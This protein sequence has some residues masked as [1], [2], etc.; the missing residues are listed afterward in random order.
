MNDK[1]IESIARLSQSLVSELEIVVRET[2]LIEEKN[3]QIDQKLNRLH[4]VEDRVNRAII[5]SKAQNGALGV[6]RKE[7]EELHKS[8]SNKQTLVEKQTVVH[9]NKAKEMDQRESILIEREKVLSERDTTITER[10]SKLNNLKSILEKEQEGVR[11]FKAKLE[12]QE[13]QLKKKSDRIM[14]IIK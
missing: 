4:L 5:D 8:I 10:E 7:L 13:G 3:Q 6:E 12:Y 14:N 11:E 9:R 1:T 2:A